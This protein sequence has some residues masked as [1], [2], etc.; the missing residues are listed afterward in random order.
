MGAAQRFWSHPSARRRYMADASYW[1]YLVHLPLVF[2]LQAAVSAWPLHWTLK[3][4]LVCA[5]ATLLL[6][7]SYDAAVRSTWVGSWLNGGVIHVALMTA[8]SPEVDPPARQPT[9]RRSAVTTQPRTA[10]C[11]SVCSV[12]DVIIVGAKPPVCSARCT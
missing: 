12:P 10:A 4:P 1:I 2:G 9:S 3:F 6:L 7:L 5:T 11:C 8:A